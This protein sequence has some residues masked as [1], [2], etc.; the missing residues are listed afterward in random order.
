MSNIRRLLQG[1]AAPALPI[2][3]AEYS[4]SF[5]NRLNGVLRLYFNKID[6]NF[7]ALLD[8]NGGGLLNNPFGEV[9]TIAQQPLGAINSP[10]IIVLANLQAGTGITL[11]SNKIKFSIDGAYNVQYTLQINNN[12]TSI[13]DV[14][15][16][17][18]DNGVDIP[19]SAFLFTVPE[20]HG[21][22]DG[23]QAQTAT[24]VFPA[25]AGDELELVWAATST[26][27]S[28]F[29]EAAQTV[30]YARPSVPSARVALTFVS[31]V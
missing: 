7:G 21:G 23:R 24:F 11:A 16:W 26:L 15:V 31:A 20:R 3:E 1:F 27:V 5:F 18:R 6:T 19:N 29:Y 30:P 22:V 17:L 9:Y 4:Q 14:T 8:V 28:L 10:T 13:Q 25:V 2:A 12:S